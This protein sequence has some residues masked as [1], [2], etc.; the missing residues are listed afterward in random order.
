MNETA[1]VYRYVTEST[2]DAYLWQ[3][4]ENKQKFIS[5]IMTSKSPVRSCDDLD[6][7]ALSFAEIKALCAGNPKIKM[8]MD[9]DIE[10]SKLKLLRANHQ[11]IQYRLEDNLLKFF[12]ISIKENENYIVGFNKDI[13]TLESNTAASDGFMPMQIQG[14]VLYERKNAGLALMKACVSI[15]SSQPKEIGTYRGFTMLLAYSAFTS[16]HKLTL[17]GEMSHEVTLGKDGSG[18]LTRIDNVLEKMPVRLKAAQEK[19]ESLLIQKEAAKEEL[20]KPFAQEQE[21]KDKVELLAQLDAELNL[22][23]KNN[24]EQKEENKDEITE[25]K[26][27]RVSLIDRLKRKPEQQHSQKLK[28]ELQE[29]R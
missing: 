22:G 4:L 2:F 27:P 7:S 19:L 13:K 26:T 3:T 15:K 11:S 17:K 6:E 28:R 29:V 20:G 24:E 12:P 8:K 1:Y 18:N 23:D 21:Y 5:Q 9:L 10:V 25:T 14:N 16:E